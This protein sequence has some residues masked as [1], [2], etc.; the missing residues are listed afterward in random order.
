[1]RNS[2]FSYEEEAPRS[3]I[4]TITERQNKNKGGSVGINLTALVESIRQ[5]NVKKLVED[6]YKLKK[7]IEECR[8]TILNMESIISEQNRELEMSIRLIEEKQ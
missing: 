6:P 5:E 2:R 7:V 3:S 4:S 8:K 1:M